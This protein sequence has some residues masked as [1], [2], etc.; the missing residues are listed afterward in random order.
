[1]KKIDL[2]NQRFGRLV[3]V[4][5][6]EPYYKPSGQKVTQWLCKCDCGKYVNVRTGDLRS[7]N[8]QSC[9]CLQ[10]DMASMSNKRFN[11]FICHN[12]Y[13][14]MFTINKNNSFIIDIDDFDKIKSICWH[15]ANNGYVSGMLNGNHV[16]LHR[17]IMNC[18]KKL[19]VDH[20]NHNLLDNR[21]SNLRLATN[22]QQEMNKGLSKTNSSGVK[23]V[24]YINPNLWEAQL[25]KNGVCHRQT[26]R[27]FQEAIKQRKRW[28][29]EYFKEFNYKESDI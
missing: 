22:S 24:Y 11:D 12:D 23:G 14:E 28:E 15:V 5:E 4:K 10:K 8:T 3:V 18:P 13:I 21:K 17:L 27:T 16:Y 20:I 26:F 1:M 9:G 19:T 25:T 6:V 29:K 2:T 7:G